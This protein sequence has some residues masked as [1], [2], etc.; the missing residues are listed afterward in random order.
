MTPTVQ[1]QN[2]LNKLLSSTGHIAL[3]ARAGC[4]KTSTILMA[5]D[6][7]VAA[8]PR[9]EI[10][11]CAFNKTIADEVGAKL[12][13]A[14]HTDWRQVMASTLHS[15]G[16]GLLKFAFKPEVDDKKVRKLIDAQNAPIFSQYGT[17]IAQLV[18]YA[19][20]A[21]FGFF[22]DKAIGNT[23]A[24]YELA[25]HFDVNGLDDTSEADGVVEAAQFIYRAS[26]AQTDVIDYGD[27]ILMPLVKNLRVKFGKDVIIGDE[28]QDWSPSK[29]ALVRKFL[30][31][32]TGRLIIVGDDRQAIYGFAGADAE[33][34][35]RMIRE[36]DMQ[37]MPLSVTWR[38]PKAV[39]RLAQQLVP[40]IEAAPEATEGEVIYTNDIPAL[41]ESVGPTDA[42]LC[43]NTAPLIETAY[44][45]I[46]AGKPCK[47]EGRAIGD[48]LINLARRWKVKSIDV[49]L[50]RLEAYQA[51]E[52]QKAMAK[53][54][55]SKVEEVMDRVA[56]LVEICNACIQQKR[57][58][59]EDVVEFI[60]N[61]FADTKDGANVTV[62]ATYHRSKGR[63]WQRVI[64]WEHSS[65]CPSRA[66]RQPWQ[67]QQ[68]ENLAY[69]AF[70]RAQH[71]LVF[72]G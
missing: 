60:T 11:V 16:F 67:M 54:N 35:P 69:V 25:D 21:G 10:Q 23:P 56:T 62:L 12:K 20:D 57:T 64:L 22:N 66:A 50:Q 17:Q 26:L 9:Q 24:W 27:M 1:Q 44:K 38:C 13:K 30:K 65:R 28:S 42:I 48:G 3:V 37:V 2:F 43:R 32:R 8:N 31:P 68:E 18:G 63:E 49:L 7:L 70:T 36:M 47:V 29:M 45:L 59:V 55:E 41:L 34:M 14:G 4:G 33:A 52:V 58:L 51:R 40:D 5:V 6:A 19:K 15:M 61:L 39:V 72:A 53:G 46:R 71:T